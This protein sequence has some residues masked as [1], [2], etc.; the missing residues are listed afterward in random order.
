MQQK[1]FIIMMTFVY[2]LFPN[3]THAETN[4]SSLKIAYVKDGYLWTKINNKDQKITSKQAAYAYPPQWS[5]DGQFILY[6]KEITQSST[7]S[8]PTQSEIWV[9]SLKT[10]K[11][12]LIFNDGSNPKWSPN[13]NIIAFLDGGVLN[14]SDFKQFYNIALG[15]DDFN[16]FPDGK[17]FI[18]SSS[19]S[20]HPD[21]WTNPI[22]Y[23]I[24]LPNDLKNHKIL[25]ENVNQ[26]FVIPKNLK[27]G[28]VSIPSINASSFQFSP[29]QKWISFI[30]SPTAS[31]SMDSNLLC[32]ITTD[33]K[34]F[35]VQDE[36]IF[37]VDEPKWA[38]Q[39]NILGYIA[40]G[41]RLVA[42]FKDKNLKVT[43]MPAF[44]ST[45][46]TPPNFTELGFTW[47]NDSTIIVSRVVETEWSNDPKKRPKPA[48]F[49]VNIHEP[50]QTK[51]TNPPKN[52][53]DYSPIYS[54]SLNKITWLRRSDLAIA[55]DLWMADLN[56]K[57]S[58]I[59]IKKVG[60]YSIFNK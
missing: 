46:L 34:I 45:N 5:F 26:F 55:G 58:K 9:Y 43:E 31:W 22:L 14:V 52:L 37:Q 56:G 51:I 36:V 4:H 42:G 30:V 38:F 47:C 12:T 3:Q 7:E 44:T 16:W 1:I 18:A 39:K 15:V 32:I 48:L 29:N 35:E 2:L 19:A 60:L 49:L 20:L 11:H 57:N 40:G 41:G 27:K 23:K 50:N 54:T 10:K 24:P 59:L 13:R 25:T 17:S 28:N 33:G 21:G 8:Y 6:Q 53:G